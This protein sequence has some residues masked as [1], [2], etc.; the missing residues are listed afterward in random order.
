M[1]RMAGNQ[2]IG[3]RLAELNRTATVQ[4]ADPPQAAPDPNAPY[5]ANPAVLADCVSLVQRVY[6]ML[7]A[8]TLAVLRGWK[9]IAIGAVVDPDE[10][11]VTKYHWTA[12]GNWNDPGVAAA[13]ASLGVRRFDADTSRQPRGAQG[14]P[15]DAEQRLMSGYDTLKAIAVSRPPCGDCAP[16]LDDYGSEHG[17]VLI[18]VV[19]PPTKR[20]QEAR[21]SAINAI[22]AAAQRVRQQLELYEGEHKVQA[23][24]INEPS[25]TG[26]AGYW[27]NRLFN[28]E[29]PPPTIW[30]NAYGSLLAVDAS[31]ARGAIREATINL[32]RA[33]RQLLVALRSYA[34]WKDGIEAAGAKAQV[35]I[36]AIAIATIL[37]VVA[38]PAIIEGVIEAATEGAAEAGAEATE[39]QLATR[40]AANI[41]RADSA[42]LALEGEVTE[43]EIEAEAL[44]ETNEFY[45]SM[46]R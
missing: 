31:L 45:A 27:T 20:E 5:V 6:A 42:M 44:A 22:R 41:E 34:S 14:A 11:N 26:F 35:A 13:M 46:G 7:D 29:I 30:I 16:A 38:G 40:I 2:A 36:A 43:A 37:A 25:F 39:E 12:A 23:A 21:E 10:P 15:G 24:L 19:P 8:A 3:L 32:I 9:T 1:Q 28:R 18:A 4:R 33:R 17:R